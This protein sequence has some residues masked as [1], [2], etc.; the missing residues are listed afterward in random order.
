M[1]VVFSNIVG[2]NLAKLEMYGA[3][4][5]FFDVG[6]KMQ[7]LWDK[8]YSDCDAV[9]FCWKVQDDPDVASK[10][11]NPNDDDSD[12]PPPFDMKLQQELLH[13]VR[14]SI[15]DD[16]PFL[17]LGHVFGNVHEGIVNRMYNTTM[18][19][20]RYHNPITAMCCGS[21]KTGAGIVY[22]MDWLVPLAKRLQKERV[23]RAT[24]QP[25][26]V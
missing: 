5:H 3:M 8:Y 23:G 26:E 17:V 19:L 1:I 25:K 21:A 22:A 20:P 2:T 12:D 24:L 9:I 14:Q 13:Q 16:V 18:L 6:G 11:D 4:C 7:S 15:P 10:D